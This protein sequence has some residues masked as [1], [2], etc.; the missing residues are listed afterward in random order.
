ML[1]GILGRF[2]ICMRICLGDAWEVSCLRK[3]VILEVPAFA[4][5]TV[6][7]QEIPASEKKLFWRF[8]HPE[9]LKMF[10]GYWGGSR[11]A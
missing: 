3:K 7:E 5:M 11:F 9:K 8:S 10:V 4:G 1:L 2:P 6:R